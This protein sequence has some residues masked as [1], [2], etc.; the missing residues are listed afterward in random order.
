[1]ART[2]RPDIRVLFTS[3]YTE[4]AVMY[5][6][7]IVDRARLLLKP[8]MREELALRIRSALSKGA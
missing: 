7:K 8:Y 6:G 2:E 3:W 5:C 1:M 4:S